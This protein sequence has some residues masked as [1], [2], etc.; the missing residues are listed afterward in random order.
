MS[1][2]DSISPR[3]LKNDVITPCIRTLEENQCAKTCVW[4][5][6]APS[7]REFFYTLLLTKS[8]TFWVMLVIIATGAKLHCYQCPRE[9]F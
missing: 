4:S 5:G 3:N 9:H 7:A 6:R 8:F 2:T 1:Y